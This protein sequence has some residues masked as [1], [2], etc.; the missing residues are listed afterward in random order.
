MPARKRKCRERTHDWQEIQQAML[1]PEQEVHERLRPIVLFGETAAERAQETGGSPRTLQ[2]QAKRFEQEGM[3]SLFHKQ[4]APS[5][6]QGRSLPQ[7]MRQLIV[8]L[9]AE[10]PGFRPHEIA[11][12]CFLRFG[13]KPSDHTVKRVLADGPKP[14]VTM[15]RYPPYAQIADPYQRRR[16]IV[17]LHAEG[18]SNTSISAYLQTPRPR[19]YEVLKRWAQEGHAG[20]DDKPSTPHRP[21]RKAGIQEIHEVGK[22]V[23]DSPELGAYRVRAA[24]EQIGIKLSQTTCGRLLALNRK[25]YGLIKPKGGPPREKKEMPFKASYRQEYWCVDVRYIEEH[26]LGFPEP[27]YLISILESYSRA[28]LASKISATQNQW[29]YLEVLFAALSRFGA[30]KAIVSDGGGIFSSRQALD[31]YAA[32]GIEKLRIDP[33][34]AWQNLIESHF[35]IARRMSDAKFARA[36]SWEEMLAIHRSFMHDY[37]VQRHWAHE[38]REDGCHSPAQVMGWHKGTM[39]PT[40]F[41]DRILF[42]TRFTRH[43]DKN[44]FLRFQNWKLYGERG[45]GSTPVTVWV[46]DGSLKV[47]YQAVTLAKYTVELQDDHKHLREVKNPRLADTPFRS[48]QLALFDLKPGEWLLYWKTPGHAPAH[49]RRSVPGIIQLPLFELSPLD[50]AVGADTG[51]IEPRSRIH[52]HLVGEPTESQG[53]EE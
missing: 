22:L 5:P 48:P 4:P 9:K 31:V 41:L 11:R 16:A 49:R 35:N 2:L 3:A 27:V 25:L 20:L 13:R 19:V 23:K 51:R 30:P 24:L 46:Y 47:E 50:M 15:R 14:S 12:I 42:A 34:Q 7:E 53:T 33:R 37:N 43:L 17:D 32:L 39:Y 1:W 8:D 28:I 26:N 21:A 36:T 52:L 38:K 40:E 10:H 44:G 29:D 45:L 6:D 18:W